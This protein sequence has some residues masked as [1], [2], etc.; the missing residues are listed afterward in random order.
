MSG[1][2]QVGVQVVVNVVV[3]RMVGWKN[4]DEVGTEDA[5]IRNVTFLL[6]A[7]V[8]GAA[9]GVGGNDCYPPK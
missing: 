7:D 5:S 9:A 1:Y 4:L 2:G 3:G 8:T 6:Y